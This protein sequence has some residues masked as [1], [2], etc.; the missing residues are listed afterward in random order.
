MS[1]LSNDREDPNGRREKPD[2]HYV[3]LVKKGDTNA[4]RILVE[5]H[6]KRMLNIAYRMMGDYEEACE[7]VQ[8]AFLSAFR[9]IRTFRGGAAFSTWL[10]SI[11]MNHGRNRIKQMKSRFFHEGLSIDDPRETETG[12]V[13]SDPP[14]GANSP[15]EHLGQKEIQQKVQECIGSLDNEFR[16]VLVLR[17]I[18]GFSYDDIRAILK[19]PDGTVKSRLFRARES[20]KNCLKKA[21]GDL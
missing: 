5:R 3:S 11:T 19:L 6:Q 20:V 12:R 1:T 9:A 13:T 17:D 7:V 8:E 14:S 2:E 10:T 16:E 4:F 18:Q 15:E 21:L